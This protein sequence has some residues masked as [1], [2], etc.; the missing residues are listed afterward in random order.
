M[1]RQYL[2]LLKRKA[3]AVAASL[4]MLVPLATV[5]EEARAERIL[6]V[7]TPGFVDPEVGQEVFTGVTSAIGRATPG[8]RVE[9]Y[10][11]LSV[12][13][14]ASLTVPE[15]RT[16]V[17]RT[18]KLRK[19]LAQLRRHL[20]EQSVRDVG[21]M[22]LVNLPAFYR[23]V[24][25]M[26]IKPPAEMRVI[27]FG[28]LLPIDMRG[29][30]PLCQVGQV[31][32]DAWVI[33]STLTSQYGTQDLGSAYLKNVVVD[34]CSVGPRIPDID[35]RSLERFIA[36]Y[37]HRLGG[38]IHSF[39]S[40]AK[41]TVDLALQGGKE[42]ATTDQLNEADTVKEIRRVG[43]TEP[44]PVQPVPEQARNALQGAGAALPRAQAG[45]LHVAAVWTSAGSADVDLYVR[46]RPGSAELSFGMTRSAEGR[47]LRDVRR[48][49]ATGESGS[50]QGD[51]EGV[52]LPNGD[53]KLIEVWLNVFTSSGDKI[54]GF[55]RIQHGQNF[56]V[57]VPFT[58]SGR[59][60]S[61]GDAGKRDRSSS[62]LRIDV[63][64]ALKAIDR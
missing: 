21:R 52:E 39:R 49:Q 47:Y 18:N 2:H 29:D 22:N 17:I 11:A 63:Q 14:I 13:L 44:I 57:D 27:I 9:I 41:L 3:T 26:R 61:A 5:A 55:V 62:W 58:M 50:W 6:V 8:D 4:A 64:A 37:T 45:I 24:A 42:P 25:G 35:R 20:T 59:A 43:G 1:L 56:T 34:Y 15:G 38:V 12:K 51:W 53:P 48:S 46:P 10:D 36:I 60:D 30:G 33:E 19:E 16:E 28:S 32:S 31:P 54:T 40:D 23:H 7:G